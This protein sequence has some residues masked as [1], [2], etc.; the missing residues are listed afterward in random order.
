M[1]EEVMANYAVM[2]SVTPRLR[3]ECK[4]WLDE[5]GWNGS[6]ERLSIAVRAGSFQEAKADIEIALGKHIESL[7]RGDRVATVERAA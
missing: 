7:L 2:L 6:N 4:F 3:I 5:G 1:A